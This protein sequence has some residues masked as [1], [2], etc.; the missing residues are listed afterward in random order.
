MKKL[1]SLLLALAML[2]TA[3]TLSG[4][5]F[6]D[7]GLVDDDIDMDTHGEFVSFL[8]RYNSKNDGF[9][10]SFISIDAKA[11]PYLE[12]SIYRFS[13]V[14]NYGDSVFYDN[15]TKLSR[16]TM[17]FYLNEPSIGELKIKCFYD[18]KDIHF[19]DSDNFEINLVESFKPQ[20][21]DYVDER[22]DNYETSAGK[23]KFVYQLE[24]MI[25][26]NREMLI[27]ISSVNEMSE[28]K[29]EEISDMLLSEMIVINTWR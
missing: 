1:T 6:E 28:E 18:K 9:K 16:I 24:L 10:S 5:W 26:N 23:Y 8:E 17:Y 22:T 3:L 12:D 19:S 20:Y 7:G 2:F 25:N 27:N 13:A 11:I 14:H 29:I 4:C 21:F 15:N